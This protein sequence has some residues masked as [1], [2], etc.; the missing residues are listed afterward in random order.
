G[1]VDLL[2]TVR[3]TLG[4]PVLSGQGEIKG[5]RM[6]VPEL[7]QSIDSINGFLS[8]NESRISIDGVRAR[9]GNN[10]TLTFTGGVDLPRA[11][12]GLAYQINA[13]AHDISV[14]FPE[15]L[16]NRGNARLSLIDDT[17]GR[18]IEGRVD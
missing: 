16:N 12:R 15:F 10:G 17:S 4:N 3:G 1:A 6:I 11:G 7:A 13:E 14:R 9:M 18:R 2:G 5:G 8:F